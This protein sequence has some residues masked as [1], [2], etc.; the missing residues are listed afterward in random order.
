VCAGIGG[1]MNISKPEI[2]FVQSAMIVGACLTIACGVA[3]SV[4]RLHP[5]AVATVFFGEGASTNGA[6]NEALV[7]AKTWDLPLLF[8]C[9]NNGL[10]G[11]TP[12]SEYLPTELVV[13]R[14]AAYGIQT[15]VCDGSDV[16]AVWE[17]A[18]KAVDYV[19][20]QRHPY[21]LE[22]LVARINRHKVP[23]FPDTR[24]FEAKRMARMRDPL[25]KL[26]SALLAEGLISL[27]EISDMYEEIRREIDVAV[28]TAKERPGLG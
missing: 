19:R 2:G 20:N 23:R 11:N 17:A 28:V 12:A 3:L 15:N 16:V 10:S 1:E 9:E 14:A 7:L 25:P 8:A 26:K 6:F 13:H 5:L 18:Q 22:G 4:K 27:P 21:F 24:T